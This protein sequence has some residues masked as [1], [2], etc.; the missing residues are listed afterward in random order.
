LTVTGPDGLEGVDLDLHEV[1]ELTPVIAAMAAVAQSP[2]RLRGVA[3]LRGHETDRLAALATE[4]GAIGCDARE[5]ADGLEIR[6][7]PLTGGL[8][9]TYA[10]HRMAHA[11]A[12]L[13]LVVPGVLVDDIAA[14]SKTHPDFVGAWLAMLE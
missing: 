12:V 6:P 3:H 7:R 8:F 2:S 1:G 11:A 4:L 10:D 14:T 13:G 9:H 5:S